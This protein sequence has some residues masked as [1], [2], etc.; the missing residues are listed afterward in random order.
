[1]VGDRVSESAGSDGLNETGG[2]GR[3]VATGKEESD[4][5]HLF[6]KRSK[7]DFRKCGELEMEEKRRRDSC[8]WF[9]R[10]PGEQERETAVSA[11]KGRTATR[12]REVT[13][14]G[15]VLDEAGVV[16]G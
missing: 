4:V 1:M 6:R 16:A 13:D 11:R 14:R 12:R 5:P 7:A 2:G 10:N 9:C 15:F 3:G 8:I